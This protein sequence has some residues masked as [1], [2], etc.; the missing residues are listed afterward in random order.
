MRF[1][2]HQGRFEQI[3]PLALKASAVLVALVAIALPAAVGAAD[4]DV[5]FRGPSSAGIDN[6]A[7]T[8]AKPESRLWWNDGSWWGILYD[9]AAN[10]GYRIWRLDSSSQTWVNT[11]VRV[12]E[13]NQSRADALWD[14]THLYV[15]SHW[16]V[17]NG[18]SP[19]TGQEA[20]LYRYSYDDAGDSY[21]LDPG[22]P[23]QISDSRSEALVLEKDSTGKLWATWVRDS[24]VWVNRTLGDDASWGT[25]FVLPLPQAAGLYF[26][27]IASIVA[28]PGKVGVMWSHQIDDAFYWAEHV[29]GQPDDAWTLQTAL[30]APDM[31]DDHINLKTDSAGRVYAAV[32]TS[33]TLSS[34]PLVMLLVRDPG[35]GAWTSHVVGT[36]GDHHTRPI[37]VLDE[38][39]GAVT[40]LAT[41]PEAGGSIYKKTAPMNTLSFPPGKG[42]VFIRDTA[43]ADMN[44]ATSTKRGVSPA[45]ALAV[46]ASNDTTQ[47]YWHNFDPLVLDAEFTTS[48][49]AG[50]APFTVAFT[51]TSKG[52]PVSWTWD[53]G[54]GTTSSEENPRHTYTSPGR[55][56]VTLTAA[57]PTGTTNVET[58]VGLVTVRP[59]VV[60]APTDDSWTRS[61]TP[62]QNF[63]RQIVVNVKNGTAT[64]AFN[65]A[66][67]RFVVSGLDRPVLDAKLR[68]WVT[69]GSADGGTAYAVDGSWNEDAITWTNAPPIDGG[70]LG[71]AG[72]VA[73][74]TWID[75]PLPESVFAAGDGVYA[76]ALTG[77]SVDTA[78]YSSRQGVNPPQLVLGVP[79]PPVADF[80]A[81]P[82]SGFTP[83]SV[84]FSDLTT[85]NP[86]SWTWDFGDGSSS[87]ER[88]PTHVYTTP[89]T[90]TVT[91]SV[92]A[93][94]GTDT[95][96]KVGYVVAS[97]PPPTAEFSA[98]PTSGYAPL[99]VSFTDL[100]T[101]NPT[102]WAWNFGDGTSSTLRN[103]SHTY[104]VPGTYTVTLT[105][106][107]PQGSDAETKVGYVVALLRPNFSLT[108]DPPSRNFKRG[109]AKTFS[110]AVTPNAAF[111]GPVQLSVS[112]VPAGTAASFTPNPV[113]VGTAPAT[114]TL[115]VTTSGSTPF[116]T[117]K[118]TVTG[119]G[120]GL[121]RTT[122]VTLVVKR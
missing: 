52:N 75:I 21:T 102:S 99:A 38:A 107:N 71:S 113:S 87:T 19:G 74:G 41:S 98:S 29:D 2:A 86:T 32:K 59:S 117:F 9:S 104:T 23:V 85:E 47:F 79:S 3:K 82:T 108:A 22:F 17:N 80:S 63:G 39:N 115:R 13:R 62:D 92:A 97:P 112:G 101:G 114:S 66:Y 67:F 118:V 50:G 24:Q 46:L 54:D 4:G 7:P 26:D 110:I 53:F 44:D 40:V 8:G 105:A 34:Q 33:Q 35:T 60:V 121:V 100:S 58:K 122:V 109:E 73:A 76:F 72:P 94:G 5:G 120:G 15:A 90:Y 27:D 55:Y 43:S 57:T 91:L 49:T 106:T 77:A 56:T 30:A 69:D 93:P 51:D 61:T 65:R 89:G 12:D 119:T 95:E 28:L 88:N 48:A 11:G 20:R 83:L 78:T 37:V 96:T 64:T 81:Q 25:P 70:A 1:S 111:S 68:L 14:G 31:A 84:A 45:T 103:P 42:T 10:D 18:G 16:F 36:V 116:G 6:S